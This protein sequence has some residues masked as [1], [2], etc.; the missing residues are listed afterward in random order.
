[1]NI[2]PITVNSTL[3]AKRSVVLCFPSKADAD[4]PRWNQSK[5]L[6]T[7]S[8]SGLEHR[9]SSRFLHIKHPVPRL[10][11]FPSQLFPHVA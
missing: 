4:G 7:V 10:K 11:R 5:P 3:Q 2:Q 8:L 9:H 6:L 1:M